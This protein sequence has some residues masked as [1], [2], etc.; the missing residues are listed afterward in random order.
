MLRVRKSRPRI[1]LPTSRVRASITNVVQRGNRRLNPAY[2]ETIYQA[3]YFELAG[4]ATWLQDIPLSSPSGGTAS[5]SQLYLLL[6]I[7]NRAQPRRL[8]ELGVGQ[9]SKLLDQYAREHAASVVHIDEDAA[10]LRDSIVEDAS[11]SGVLA[12]LVP[13]QVESRHIEWYGCPR[14]HER[15]DLLLVDGPVA[16]SRAHRFNRLGVL[17]WVPEVLQDEF[18]IIVDDSTRKGERALIASILQTL[19]AAG[20][21]VVVG[22]I[23]GAT[24]QVIIAS[25]SYASF[26]YL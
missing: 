4:R 9:S 16:F 1:D 5:F 24:S 19:H 22:E 18:A 17:A 20:I 3:S 13:T 6:S 10:W 7:L 14:P 8:L 12:P 23:V 21:A 25:A 26:T 11:V 15:F 2:R